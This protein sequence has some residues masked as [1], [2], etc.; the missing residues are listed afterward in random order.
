MTL[1]LK[2]ELKDNVDSWVVKLNTKVAMKHGLSGGDI[3]EVFN[4]DRGSSRFFRVRVDGRIKGDRCMINTES[5]QLDGAATNDELEILKEE[6]V[7]AREVLVRVE[8][9]EAERE[10]HPTGRDSDLRYQLS[11]GA[12]GE[13]PGYYRYAA[14]LWLPFFFGYTRFL[15][16]GGVPF[17]RSD[18]VTEGARWGSKGMVW[19][20]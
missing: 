18:A 2:A 12:Y 14:D 15:S 10:L 8:M 16:G 6:A 7:D 20:S 1:N 9:E 17:L 19:M 11:S 3:C 13:G 4:R 5:A